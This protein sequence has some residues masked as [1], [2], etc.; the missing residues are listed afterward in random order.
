MRRVSVVKVCMTWLVVVFNRRGCEARSSSDRPLD[1]ARAPPVA[2][3]SSPPP[4]VGKVSPRFSPPFS[5]PPYQATQVLCSRRPLVVDFVPP[6]SL[7]PL[8]VP[9]QTV[10]KG[11]QR[12]AVPAL[13]A[14]SLQYKLHKVSIR[15]CTPLPFSYTECIS[16]SIRSKRAFSLTLLLL[17]LPPARSRHR[18][19]A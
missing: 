3:A 2:V 12:R 16:A 18:S 13:L 7:P 1:F 6:P 5:P 15:S 11:F 10:T 8:P 19:L 4:L 14:Y 9:P 17:L